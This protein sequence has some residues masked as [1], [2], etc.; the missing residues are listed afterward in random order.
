MR[1]GPAPA[2]ALARAQR[3]QGHARRASS[4]ARRVGFSCG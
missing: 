4:Y 1:T 3:G 2:T